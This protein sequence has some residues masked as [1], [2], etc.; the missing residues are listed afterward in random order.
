MGGEVGKRL[1]LQTPRT[2]K[3]LYRS[4]LP[5]VRFMQRL[6][7]CL[8]GSRAD[9]AARLHIRSRRDAG[10][11]EFPVHSRDDYLTVLVTEM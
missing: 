2:S 7:D 10:S 9:S 5:C 4:Y 6:V 8:K 11:K 3:Y 1:S